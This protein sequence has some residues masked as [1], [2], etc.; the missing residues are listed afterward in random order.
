MDLR[1]LAEGVARE[2]IVRGEEPVEIVD[3]AYD[4][5][6]VVRGTLFFCVPGL[7][8]D[9]HDFAP[10]AVARG[11][12]ALVCQRRLDL[13]VSQVLVDD[14]R[15]AMA[16]MAARF[17]GDPSTRLRVVG[18]TGTN[19]KTTTTFLVRHLL[20][21]AGIRCGLLG[22][23][24][25]VI[26]GE[27]LPAQRTTPESL[28]LQ[29]TFARMVAAGD[30]AC[31][32]EVSSHALELGRVRG[33]RFAC[34]VFTNL[35][36]DHLDFH[37]TMDA[38]FAAK[39]R[40]FVE[41]EGPAVVGI[42]NE[43][44]RRLARELPGAVTFAIDRPAELRA[45]D[46]EFDLSGARFTLLAPEQRLRCELPLPGR[47][48]VENA[49]AALAAVRVLGVPLEQAVAALASFP[50]VP[51]RFERIDE[52]QPFGVLVDYAHTPDSL[53]R[54]LRA[55]RPLCRGRLWCVFGCGGDRDRGK[56]PQMGRIAAAL[57]DRV[58]VTSDNPRSEDP[59][60][61][62]DEIVAGIDGFDGVV[63]EVDRRRAIEL[64]IAAAEPGDLVVIA[65][66]GHE[67]GQEFA[68]G[69]IEP[70]DDREVARTALLARLG[71]QT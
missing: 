2:L 20:E 67:Q 54:L 46:V 14:V 25:Q 71:A 61:I 53:E 70:F 58:V 49:L 21:E 11:A 15:T 35:T 12:A 47:F 8:A 38:Y 48:N 56:R 9:G 34:K 64:A 23:V 42:D 55:A 60:A 62:I 3:L 13:P 5:R 4:S 45:V 18:V 7:R 63:R 51:G 57:A 32:M 1:L 29:R 16:L 66:K 65:G 10:E 6:R 30:Q 24:C 27:Q 33:T 69:R 59:E 31:A 52:G 26:G 44:G 37:G 50:A 22:T 36:Q 19:G 43:W 39:R 41:H 28:D 68:H 40:L 17:F